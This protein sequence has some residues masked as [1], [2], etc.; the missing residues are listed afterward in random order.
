MGRWAP[1]RRCPACGSATLATTSSPDPHWTA[2]VDPTPEQERFWSGRDAQWSALVGSSAGGRLVDVGCGFGHFVGWATAHGW[3]AWGV[4][5]DGW[6]R[7]RTEVPGRIVASLDD[8]DGMFDVATLW[9]VLEHVEA[10]IA[11]LTDLGRRVKPGG[12]VVVGVPDFAALRW[13]WPLLRLD[14]RRFS[15]VVRPDEHV[16][17]FTA[18]GLVLALERS[19]LADVHVLDAPLSRSAPPVVATLLRR[20][21][22]LRR[23]LFAVGHRT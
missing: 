23:G 11:F 16:V 22:A 14:G 17:Q 7:E 10:P 19:G 21:P 2:N 8:L 1:Y 4:D 13:R 20:V 5:D 15:D 3:D 6:A 18:A 12:R 9:D